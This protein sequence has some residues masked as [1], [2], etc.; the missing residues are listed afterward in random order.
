MFCAIN[1]SVTVFHLT[2]GL[3]T[4][5][6][7]SRSTI[8]ALVWPTFDAFLALL[9]DTIDTRLREAVFDASLARSCLVAA[10]AGTGAIGALSGNDRM[11][12]RPVINARKKN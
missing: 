9:A 10:F 4:A 11:R 6:V 3:T 8:L 1:V 2:A 7:S 5:P 12:T